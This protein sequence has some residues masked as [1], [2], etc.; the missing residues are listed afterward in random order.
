MLTVSSSSADKY[1]GHT[2]RHDFQG[3]YLSISKN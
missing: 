1:N 2:S 3:D